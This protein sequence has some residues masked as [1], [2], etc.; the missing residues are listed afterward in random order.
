M[1]PLPSFPRRREPILADGM[2]ELRGVEFMDPRLRGD[3][4]GVGDDEKVWPKVSAPRLFPREGGD[5]DWAPAF[6][7]EQEGVASV[8]FARWVRLIDR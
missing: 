6:A 8:N 2:I 7:G 1:Q 5:P 3:D 4:D